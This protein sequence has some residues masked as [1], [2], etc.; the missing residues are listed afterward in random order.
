VLRSFRD[1]FRLVLPQEGYRRDH[2]DRF[3][4]LMSGSFDKDRS[5]ARMVAPARC[6]VSL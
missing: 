6:G 1:G 4:A 5:D 3:A 2:E